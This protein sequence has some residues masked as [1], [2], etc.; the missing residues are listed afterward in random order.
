MNENVFQCHGE[1]ADKQEFLKTVGVLEEHINK[2]FTYPQDAA[3]ICK[4]FVITD[5][6]QPANLT[7]E[8]YKD[9]GKKMI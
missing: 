1:H 3:S 4:T 9:M 8:Q 7:D 5:L 6:V 2:N